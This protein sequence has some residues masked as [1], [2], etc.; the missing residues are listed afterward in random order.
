MKKWQVLA[1]A[2]ALAAAGGLKLLQHRKAADAAGL[3]PVHVLPSGQALP[4]DTTQY[5]VPESFLSVPP[6]EGAPSSY[7]ALPTI[8]NEIY[9]R[10][11]CAGGSLNS[12]LSAHGRVWGY[13]SRHGNFREKETAEIYTLL[14]RYL[15]C[16]G[17]SRRAPSFCDYLPGD[18]LSAGIGRFSSPNYRCREN[19]MNISF[20][21]YAAGRDKSESSCAIVLTGRGL[22]EGPRLPGREFCAAAASGMENVCPALESGFGAAKAADCRRQVPG[23]AEDCGSDAACRS[24]LA[25][26]AAMKSG[27]AAACPEEYRGLCGAFLSGTEAACSVML[28]KLG[29]SYCEYLAGAQKRSRGYAGL[30]PEEVKEALRKDSEAKAAER[31]RSDEAKK[32]DEEVN[33]RA[34]QMIGKAGEP[35]A[36]GKA[37]EPGAK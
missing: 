30:N 9:D 21:G 2:L 29:S 32:I 14:A 8:K 26:Y 37:G 31:R 34:R 17:L 35:G 22:S 12:I 25:V 19:Y 6:Q 36:T 16:V 33:W 23:K 15:A 18:N 27:D 13:E 7:T 24:R 28:V 20:P 5:Y 10:G 1:A 4:E 3:P 11:L